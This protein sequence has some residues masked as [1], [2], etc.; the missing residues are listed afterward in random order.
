MIQEGISDSFVQQY[1]RLNNRHQNYVEESYALRS[2]LDR[3]QTR[4]G[5]R[6]YRLKDLNTRLLPILQSQLLYLESELIVL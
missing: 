3:T 2:R 6:A 1:L 4:H 5:A